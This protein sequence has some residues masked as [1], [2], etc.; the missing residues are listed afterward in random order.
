MSCLVSRRWNLVGV[1]HVTGAQRAPLQIA[2]LDEQRV[3]AAAAE[4]AVLGDA[5]LLAIDR[6][7]VPVSSTTILGGAAR[8]P[9][10]CTDQKDRPGRQIFRP[11]R[12]SVSNRPTLA[13]R[14]YR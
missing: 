9:C 11:V 6:A 7:P 1:V 3:V 5:L 4:M 10:S 2:K 14:A 12:Q 8:A 13:V